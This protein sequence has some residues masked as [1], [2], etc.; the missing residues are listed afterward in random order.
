[1]QIDKITFTPI[2][3]EACLRLVQF[4]N[5]QPITCARSRCTARNQ[6]PSEALTSVRAALGLK[7]PAR[8]N[9]RRLSRGLNS[10][11]KGT[12][13]ACASKSC[14]GCTG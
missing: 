11:F 14:P 7:G 3:P 6:T 4:G 2:K 8:K 1:M 5:G 12:Q 10:K 13:C 9:S